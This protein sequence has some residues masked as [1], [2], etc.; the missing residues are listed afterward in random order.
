MLATAGYNRGESGRD[1]GKEMAN[2]GR[3]LPG[4]LRDVAL[5]DDWPE[6]IRTPAGFGYVDGDDGELLVLR[7]GEDDPEGYALSR[8]GELDIVANLDIPGDP[9]FAA[10]VAPLTVHGWYALRRAGTSDAPD[11]RIAAGWTELLNRLH[12]DVVAQLESET[13][14]RDLPASLVTAVL[15]RQASERFGDDVE[16]L[17]GVDRDALCRYAVALQ[18]REEIAA[19]GNERG[20][21]EEFSQIFRDA[22]EFPFMCGRGA[23][24]RAPAPE[25]FRNDPGEA[26]IAAA[27]DALVRRVFGPLTRLPPEDIVAAAVPRDRSE[28]FLGALAAHAARNGD[29]GRLDPRGHAWLEA[30]SGEI[31]A[32]LGEAF[33]RAYR[34]EQAEFW[35]C[36][37][38]DILF[39]KDH[40]A[41]AFYSWPTA[42]RQLLFERDGRPPVAMI[43]IADCPSD[44]EVAGMRLRRDRLLLEAAPAENADSP[45]DRLLLD[46]RRRDDPA[47]GSDA[48]GPAP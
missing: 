17:A 47:P 9:A 13:G 39:V 45:L 20:D 10:D 24:F 41:A 30:V 6:R 2:G 43:D 4:F 44:E 46:D 1:R 3:V 11:A 26:R 8:L 7:E 48:G 34:P 35:E 15:S 14:G 19:L 25:E 22:G 40:A 5:V 32:V 18:L 31:G 21:V 42:E 33:G 38:R 12:D 23:A 16:M 28:A 37:G 27:G 29:R 36:G